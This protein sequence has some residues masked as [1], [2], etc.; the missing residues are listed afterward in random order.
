MFADLAV[1][2]IPF[3]FHH[4]WIALIYG[5]VYVLMSVIFYAGGGMINGEPYIY[6]ILDWSGDPS[7]LGIGISVATVIG[8]I[9]LLGLLALGIHM[10]TW[11][12]DFLAHRFLYPKV[13]T[14][15]TSDEEKLQA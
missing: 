4:M 5:V 9:V 11:F 10:V 7:G 2:K 13:Q 15:D 1:N 12:R 6:P 14:E 8:C 3:R